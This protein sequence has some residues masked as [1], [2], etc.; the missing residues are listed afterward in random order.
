MLLVLVFFG[1]NDVAFLS[2][3]PADKSWSAT[4]HCRGIA[5]YVPSDILPVKSKLLRVVI[6]LNMH[7]SLLTRNFISF[8]IVLCKKILDVVYK[9]VL[10]SLLLPDS[11]HFTVCSFQGTLLL[12]GFSSVPFL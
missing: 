6:S 11:Y 5:V 3:S 12:S 8:L 7:G 9:S 1:R 10:S 4:T 2:M